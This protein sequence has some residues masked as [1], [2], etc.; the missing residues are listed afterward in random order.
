EIQMFTRKYNME[1][2]SMTEISFNSVIQEHKRN[3]F[4]LIQS[5]ERNNSITRYQSLPLTLSLCQY[6]QGQILPIMEWLYWEI[7]TQ[8]VRR[9]ICS[10]ILTVPP[11]V[12]S[13]VTPTPKSPEPPKEPI[14]SRKCVSG[15]S[16]IAASGKTLVDL[17]IPYERN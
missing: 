16:S 9:C 7:Q 2:I 12:P 17:K 3:R 11:I 10:R 13:E 6:R 1:Q 4:H 15:Q 5:Q 8:F 14:P